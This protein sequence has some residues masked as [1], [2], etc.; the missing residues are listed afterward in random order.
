MANKPLVSLIMPVKNE[1]KHIKN[2]IESAFSVKTDCDFEIVVVD[3]DSQDGCCYFLKKNKN[4]KI[5][6]INTEGLG[7]AN[8]RNAGAEHAKGDIFIFCDAHLFFEDYWI[9]RLIEPIQKGIADATNP[10]IADVKNPEN[11][12]YGYTWNE[13]LEPKWNREKKKEPYPSPLLAGGCLAISRK[14]FEDIDGFERGFRVWG[15]EDEEISLKLWLFGYKCYIVPD[16]TVL[17]VFR[18]T[19][20]PFE[21]KWEHVDYN[22]LR[23][24]FLHFNYERIYNSTK[25]IKYSLKTL[26]MAE[27]LQTD[28]LEKRALYEQ[29]RKYDDDWYMKKFNIPF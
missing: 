25:Q 9:D 15:R 13:N 26:L 3:D 2:T 5:K 20:P 12:G 6:L 1:G 28:I 19:A 21:L 23:M 7:A 18:P 17:H 29:K 16:V 14:A 22:L 10:G 24:A 4:E 8:A 27:L 11:I